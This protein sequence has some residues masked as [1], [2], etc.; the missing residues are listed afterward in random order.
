M[1]QH[2]SYEWLREKLLNDRLRVQLLGTGDP[3]A[4]GGR[5]QSCTLLEWGGQR[6]LI[7]CGATTL[8]ALQQNQ[9]NPSTVDAVVVTH[10]HG[11]HAAGLPFLLLDTV[12]GASDGADRPR[13]RRPLLIAG[14]E[15]TEEFVRS[16]MDLFRWGEAFAA[17]Q[18]QGLVA[19]GTVRPGEATA[20]GPLMVTAYPALHTPEALILRVACGG[21]TVAFSGDTSW[22]DALIDA[23][24]GADMLICQAYS[25]AIPQKTVLSYEALQAQRHRLTCRRLLLT[26]IGAEMQQR[27]GEAAEEVGYDGQEIFL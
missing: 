20:V 1:H 22:T 5:M 13:R 14:P 2:H 19:Y 8:L 26:H 23:A 9:I 21:R 4:H 12:I 10:F 18:A 6:V 25:F 16:A 3:F 17:A 15:G 7:D 27:L 11:D 24:A